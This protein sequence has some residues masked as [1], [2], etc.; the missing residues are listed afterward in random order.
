MRKGTCISSD[1][2]SHEIVKQMSSLLSLDS[3]RVQGLP[4]QQWYL[5]TL[6]IME[7]NILGISHE[8]RNPYT[9]VHCRSFNYHSAEN[10]FSISLYCLTLTFVTRYLSILLFFFIFQLFLRLLF[11]IFLRYLRIFNDIV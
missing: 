7:R 1:I 9:Q 10:S 4:T 8:V 5:L 6:R 2:Y 11:K 3:P